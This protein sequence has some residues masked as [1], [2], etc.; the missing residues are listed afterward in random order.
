MRTPR[1]TQTIYK[2][3][4]GWFIATTGY[5]IHGNHNLTPIGNYLKKVC[6]GSV[7]CSCLHWYL[8]VSLDN[9]GRHQLHH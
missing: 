3:K 7:G 8:F 6:K 2:N 1:E 4:N 5:W 9:V